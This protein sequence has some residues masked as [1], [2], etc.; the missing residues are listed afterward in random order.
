MTQVELQDH[1][2]S[3]LQEILDVELE[4]LHKEIHHTDDRQYRVELKDKQAT[5]ERIREALTRT[6]A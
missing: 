4:D 1:E 6:A 3:V 2:V 5:L